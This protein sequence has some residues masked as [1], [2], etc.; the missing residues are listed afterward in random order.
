MNPIEA[1]GG[2]VPSTKLVPYRAPREGFDFFLDGKS[3]GV[4]PCVF[5]FAKGR[6][7]FEQR[8][9][10]GLLEV[11]RS[12]DPGRDAVDA[13]VEVI[14][15]EVDP[16]AAARKQRFARHGKEVVVEGY[17]MVTVPADAS[18]HV[19]KDFGKERED[20]RDFVRNA[21]SGVEVA[22]IEAEQR[23]SAHCIGEVKLMGSYRERFATDAEELGFHAV[24]HSRSSRSKRGIEAVT[25][26]FAG[27][28][29]IDWSVFVTVGNPNV[30]D[31]GSAEFFCEMCG[32]SAGA[33]H[34]LNPELANGF[35]SVR[36]CEAIGG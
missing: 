18:G 35:V 5:D 33:A 31:G 15:P 12:D 23:F 36:E 29:P 26:A 34:V 25:Q 8:D 9:E 24:A 3:R 17:H 11:A 30:V 21:F 27:G 16:F 19:E 2:I 6:G 7:G 1:D 22:G 32:D 20:S 4:V 13:R 28:D 10:Q 14:H